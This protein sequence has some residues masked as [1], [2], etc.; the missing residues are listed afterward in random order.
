MP[1]Q[2]TAQKTPAKR[3][4]TTPRKSYREKQG[5]PN[6]SILS[7]FK[8]VETKE[9]DEDVD[10][11]FLAERETSVML[12]KSTREK[13][14]AQGRKDGGEAQAIP[15]LDV[16]LDPDEDLFG[17]DRG[18][19]A[20]VLE[21]HTDIATEDDPRYNEA[22]GSVKK[23]RINN[24]DTTRTNSPENSGTDA[25]IED[26]EGCTPPPPQARPKMVGAFIDHSDSEDD[27][28]DIPP[29]RQQ[30]TQSTAVAAEKADL[31]MKV[32]EQPA[33]MNETVTTQPL[34]QDNVKENKP[35]IPPFKDVKPLS[36]STPHLKRE[37]TSFQDHDHSMLPDEISDD[38]AHPPGND[39]HDKDYAD[40]EEME[41]RRY[42][43]SQ[44]EHITHPDEEEDIKRWDPGEWADDI[45]EWDPESD[46][47]KMVEEEP[48]CPICAASLAAIDTKLAERHVNGCLDG[49]FVPLPS[50][51]TTPAFKPEIK[52]EDS[53]KKDIKST[54][55]HSSSR[56]SKSSIAK[57]GQANPI[58]MEQPPSLSG[59]SA[60]SALMS[61]KAE[62]AAWA[63][64]AA[65][66]TSARGKP[67]YQRTC[68]FY[69]IMPGM[70]ICVDAFRYGKVEGCNAYFLSHFHSDHYV[71]LSGSWSHGPIYA[72]TITATLMKQQLKVDARHVVALNFEEKTLVPG[73]PA[74]YVTMIP[75]NHCPGSSL[76]L[77]EKV[78]GRGA[79]PKIQR[80]LHC[81]DFRACPQH[82]AHPKLMPDIIDSLTN[83]TRQQKIDVCYLDTTYLNPKYAF[84]SQEEVIKSCADMCVSLSKDKADESDAW[85]RAKRE[86]AGAG[87]AKFVG[88]EVVV[89]KEEEESLAMSLNSTDKPRGRLLVIC[90]TYSIGKERICLGIARALDCK[91][92]APAGKR[93]ICAALEDEELMGRLTDDPLEAQIHMQMLMEIRAETLQD[94]LNSMKPHF[95]RIVGFRPSG[96][97]YRPPAGRF[98]ESPSVDTILRSN[99]WIS[100]FSMHELVPMRGSTREASCFGVPYSEHSSFRELTMFCCALRIEKII[101]TVNVASAATRKKMQGWIERWMAERRKN[102]PIK[103]GDGKGEVKW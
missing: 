39:D 33:S 40:G 101:P 80:I 47:G 97:N 29:A 70:S 88:K 53:E 94:Y 54:P 77:F 66:E 92:W 55:P 31:D 78:V 50:P 25:P 14:I 60:F 21:E 90:G 69:K 4:A 2:K 62:D 64:A 46:E 82:I 13:A 8:K 10:A 6:A 7:F 49:N 75:A 16:S 22:G 73:T 30:A 3:P 72:S 81:G 9:E 57:P 96:W 74:V 34:D 24:E 42:M 51:T 67:A 52:K 100:S 84:P 19:T 103:L 28:M 38:E 98:I 36:K 5:K 45:G 59:G 65:A 32:A 86:R 61:G 99:N 68:P 20:S 44:Q 91:I 37:N 63:A 76:F 58:S 85:E 12:R 48:S 83:R 89:K 15:Q 35:I 93:K 26:K 87:M 79:Q 71:G 17:A 102:G 95:S 1:A 41:S 18:L 56:F 11:L 23:R 43:Q 27:V